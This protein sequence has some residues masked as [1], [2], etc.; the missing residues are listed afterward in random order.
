[1][2]SLPT[3]ELKHVLRQHRAAVNAIA[4]SPIHIV[5][6]SGDRSVRLWD[7]ET[8]ALLRTFENHHWRGC[9]PRS[10]ALPL[11]HELT[12]ACAIASPLLTSSGH[13][14]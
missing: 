8:G 4:I 12:L 9:V 1:M 10:P 14:C 13:T 3:F 5:S 7:A 6:A 2:Y 11:L